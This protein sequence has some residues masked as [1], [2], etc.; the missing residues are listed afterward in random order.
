MDRNEMLANPQIEAV[1]NLVLRA[2]IGSCDCNTKSP[3]IIWHSPTCRYVT[4]MTTLDAIDVLK[5]RLALRSQSDNARDAVEK[6][7]LGCTRPACPRDAEDGY[8]C[9]LC[10][11]FEYDTGQRQDGAENKLESIRH[12]VLEVLCKAPQP[13]SPY[14]EMEAASKAFAKICEI[15]TPSEKVDSNA[16]TSNSN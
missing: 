12:V 5:D 15:L 1:R 13:N 2:S 3:D 7:Q 14:A 8:A 10:G 16:Q 6:R 4:L 9:S 11:R